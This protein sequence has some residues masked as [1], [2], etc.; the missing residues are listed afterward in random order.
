VGH[1]LLYLLIELG[2]A[3]L[4]AAIL[5]RR[6]ALGLAAIL[7]VLGLAVPAA[8][9]LRESQMQGDASAVGMLG[10]ICFILFFPAG[11]ALAILAW[12]KT[13]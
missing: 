5:P 10:T 4:A 7:L 13:D 1:I 12:L 6:I 2:A 11:L 3:I 8:L 9:W